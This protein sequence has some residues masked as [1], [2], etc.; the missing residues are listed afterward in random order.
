MIRTLDM[1]PATKVKL[2]QT[3]N[4]CKDIKTLLVE[5]LRH[6]YRWDDHP[7]LTVLMSSLNATV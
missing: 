2:S 4:S 6:C 3:I 5:K 7:L 1:T